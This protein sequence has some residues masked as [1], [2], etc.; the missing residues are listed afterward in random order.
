MHFRYRTCDIDVT[1]KFS[2]GRYFAHATIEPCQDLSET[3]LDEVRESGDLGDFD[4]EADAVACAH[5]WAI[6]RIDE[7]LNPLVCH[8]D[9]DHSDQSL[10][11]AN[12][13][14]SD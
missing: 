12:R 14:R 1:P 3:G 5:K 4:S 13:S 7:H 9:M 10:F 11:S 6:E 8:M 2:L